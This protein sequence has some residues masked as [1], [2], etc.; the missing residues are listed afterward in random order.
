MGKIATEQ[1][2]KDKLAY[3]GTVTSNI[4]C[5]TKERALEMKADISKLEKYKDNQL[6]QLSDLDKGEAQY[7]FFNI[8]GRCSL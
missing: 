2:A 3:Q 4:K 1:E 5:C 7:I 6:V 8:W